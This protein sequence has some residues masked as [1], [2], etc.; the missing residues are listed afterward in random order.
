MLS[1]VTSAV[2]GR[3]TSTSASRYLP[4]DLE[5]TE[6]ATRKQAATPS[7]R[8]RVDLVGLFEDLGE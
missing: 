7:V 4:L 1:S 6:P 5:K 8:L 2:L 3:S